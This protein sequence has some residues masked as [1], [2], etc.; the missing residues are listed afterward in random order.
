MKP[1]RSPREIVPEPSWKPLSEEVIERAG[2]SLVLGAADVGKSA[3]SM[4]LIRESLSRGLP[5]SLV[6]SDIGQSSLGLPGAISMK[7]FEKAGDLEHFA[8][9]EVFFVGHFSPAKKFSAMVQGTVK[10]AEAARAGGPGAVVVD[11]TGLVGGEVGRNLKTAKV[12]ALKPDDVV[13][14]QRKG[15]LE[16]IL[17]AIKGPRVHRL[18]ASPYAK[19]RSAVERARYRQERFRLYLRGS[20]VGRLARSCVE[21]SSE[22]RPLG[23]DAALEPGTLVGLNSGERT[24]AL[25]IFLGGL[26]DEVLIRTP[27]RSLKGVDRVLV[28]DVVVPGTRRN[29]K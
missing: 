26:P 29:R 10:M 14:I 23:A 12:K 28:G 24:L 25:G 4:F 8:P 1:K 3:L 9:E 20:G 18:R 6:D 17:S 27:L 15:E 11:T 21:L 5:V 13:A 7:R 22:G 2:T 16:H 19:R